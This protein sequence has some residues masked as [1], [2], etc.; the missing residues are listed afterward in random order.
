MIYL[1]RPGPSKYVWSIKWRKNQQNNQ[2]LTETI[3]KIILKY[4][5]YDKYSVHSEYRHK[6]I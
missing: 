4:R 1:C 5:F 6:Y 2:H 3:T